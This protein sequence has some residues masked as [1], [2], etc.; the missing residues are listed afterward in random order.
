MEK[1]VSVIFERRHFKNLCEQK[2]HGQSFQTFHNSK[3]SN[4]Y[5]GNCRTPVS[6]GLIRFSLRARN[7][8]LWTLRKK[9]LFLKI[10]LRVQTVGAEIIDF[11]IYYIFLAIVDTA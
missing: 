6:D 7:D 3:I 5:V 1:T 8:M 4:F 9:Q 2:G 11:V 10:R